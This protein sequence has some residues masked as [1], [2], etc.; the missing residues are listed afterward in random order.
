VTR[1]GRA[2]CRQLAAA[3][4]LAVTRDEDPWYLRNH[5]DFSKEYRFSSQRNVIVLL[6]DA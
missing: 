5:F 3:I 6:L 1:R 2:V 4:V